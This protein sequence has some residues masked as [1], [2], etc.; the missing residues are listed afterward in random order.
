MNFKPRSGYSLI[1]RQ[2]PETK[3]GLIYI[4]E[5]A[6]RKTDKAVVLASSAK[7][8]KDPDVQLKPVVKKYDVILFHVNAGQ[9]V[10]LD[11]EE[12]ELIHEDSMLAVLEQ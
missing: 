3:S 5:V 9:K 6:Q 11:G 4:P 2:E 7:K 10:E 8:S 1:K 12:Y